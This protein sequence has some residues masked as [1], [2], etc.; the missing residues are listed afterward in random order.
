M[1][2]IL[3]RYGEIGL[4]GRNRNLFVRR[5]RLNIKDCLKRNGLA[6]EVSVH[7]QRLY[8]ETDDVDAALP[9]LQRVFGIVS[10]SAVHRAPLDVEAI[11][12]EAVSIARG[13]GLGPDRTFRVEARRAF[14]GFPLTSPQINAHVGEAIRL[15]TGARVDLSDDADVTIGVEIRREEALIFAAACPGPG[16]LPL[17]SQGRVVALISGGIDSP[18]AAWLMMKR[19]CGVA[20]LHF[21]QSEVE[22]AK[23]LENCQVL[24]RYAYGWRIKPLVLSHHEIML[25]I[26]ERLHELRAERW[27]CLFC[28]HAMLRKAAQLADEIGANAIVTGENVGQVAS[29]TLASLEMISMGIGKP[30]LRPLIGYDKVDIMALARSI[31]TFG[32]STRES[33]PCPF[34]P[35]SVVTRPAMDKWLELR[36]RLADVLP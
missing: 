12:T 22:T 1:G 16:G 9:H 26:V 6:G 5:L 28:K 11:T 3:V 13:V 4:K 18:V 31:G 25:P 33:Q 17:N 23:A 21:T 19:G 8:V 35:S 32:I 10:L 20:P 7:G 15:A 36:E 29:Q 2:L 34:L 27:T 24:D 30:I 14:K